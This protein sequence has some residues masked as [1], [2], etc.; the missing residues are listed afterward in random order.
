MNNIHNKKFGLIIQK[1]LSLVTLTIDPINDSPTIVKKYRKYNFFDKIGW[2]ILTGTY[3]QIN[4]SLVKEINLFVANINY[5]L[6]LILLDNFG[7]M[8]GSYDTNRMGIST[9]FSLINN[10][11]ININ[12]L[13]I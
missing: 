9:L 11:N 13:N 5:T 1:K 6:K 10:F 7:H 8:T 12:K 4:N 3:Y 2:H